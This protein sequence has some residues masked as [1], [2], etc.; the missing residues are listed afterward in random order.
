MK[1]VCTED[2]LHESGCKIV[3]PPWAIEKDIIQ[4][5][6]HLHKRDPNILSKFEGVKSTWHD[7]KRETDALF[8]VWWGKVKTKK[9]TKAE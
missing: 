2:L 9:N 4:A 8:D 3:V 7:I 6:Y 1:R 5:Y